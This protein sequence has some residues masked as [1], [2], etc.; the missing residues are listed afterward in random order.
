MSFAA[1]LGFVHRTLWQRDKLYRWA[2]LLGP[3]P[4]LGCAAASLAWAAFQYFAPF[5]ARPSGDAP[6]AHWTRPT[7]QEGQPLA[8]APTGPLPARDPSGRFPGWQTGWVG[9]IQPIR[10]DAMFETS[11]IPSVIAHFA[12]DQTTI[13]MQPILDAGPPTGLFIGDVKTLFPVKTPGVYA[14]S[15]RFTR[16]SPQSANCLVWLNSNK[17]RLVRAISVN[18]NGNSVVNYPPTEFRLE[19][20]MFLLEIITGCWRGE[21]MVGPGELTMMVRH[22]GESALQPARAEDLIKPIPKPAATTAP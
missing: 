21:Q 22:P 7:Q 13:P 4:V 17:H 20:G 6:W 8:E 3:P 14:F 18:M 11:L 1:K 12:I 19:P 10:V 15:V 16:S 9:Q 2:V 5:A